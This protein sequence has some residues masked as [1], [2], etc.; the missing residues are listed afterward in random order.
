MPLTDQPDEV[1]DLVDDQD[2]VIGTVTREEVGRTLLALPGYV[3]AADAFIVNDR[4]ELFVPRRSSHKKLAPGGL[5][6]S[7]G[8]HVGA[9]ETYVQAMVRGFEEELGL[10]IT[11]ADLIHIG[12]LDLKKLGLIPYFDAIFIYR[13]N[14]VPDYNKDD[15][16]SHEW[17]PVAELLQRLRAGESAKVNMS[18]ALELFLQTNKLG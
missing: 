9:G 8:E 6:F 18:P 17:L 7:A 4:G 10:R 11:A 15:F 16:V 2:R 13:T 3:R 5:D 14:E 12:T 1:L